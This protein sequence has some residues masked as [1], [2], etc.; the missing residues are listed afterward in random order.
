MAQVN[1]TIANLLEVHNQY[2]KARNAAGC[3]RQFCGGHVRR[4]MRLVLLTTPVI[5]LP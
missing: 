4:E 5:V 3:A 2:A 1:L